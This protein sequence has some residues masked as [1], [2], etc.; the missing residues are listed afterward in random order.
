[1]SFA[2]LGILKLV[3]ISQNTDTDSL[4]GFLSLL[5][6]TENLVDPKV[7]CCPKREEILAI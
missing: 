2:S 7:R 5:Q 3:R 6:P 1:M 4:S